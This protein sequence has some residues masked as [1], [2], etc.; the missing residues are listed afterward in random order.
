M[1]VVVFGPS[2]MSER[3]LLRWSL[4]GLGEAFCG[5]IRWGGPGDKSGEPAALGRGFSVVEL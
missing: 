3:L 5:K 4:V 1:V 2:L